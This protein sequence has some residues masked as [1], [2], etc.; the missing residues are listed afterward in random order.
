MAMEKELTPTE[1][2]RLMNEDKRVHL[3]VKDCGTV[4][5]LKKVAEDS[6]LLLQGIKV[7]KP[8]LEGQY[9]E[10]FIDL[11]KKMKIMAEAAN[12]LE[13]DFNFLSE[14]FR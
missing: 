2:I 9:K 3:F 14:A 10:V 1:K 6:S 13:K 5:T 4:Q 12:S 7:G 8:L 11:A